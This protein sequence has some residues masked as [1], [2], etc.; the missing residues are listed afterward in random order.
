M[1]SK[2]KF[3]CEYDI[4]WPIDKLHISGLRSI[5]NMVD[6]TVI[7]REEMNVTTTISKFLDFCRVC[8]ASEQGENKDVDLAEYGIE[9]NRETFNDRYF[10]CGK[11][12]IAVGEVYFMY[13]IL[14]RKVNLR[15]FRMFKF[16]DSYFLFL[17]RERYAFIADKSMLAVGF[18][19]YDLFF[20]VHFS[21]Q[22]KIHLG[23]IGY[24]K[25]VPIGNIQ[26]V[27]MHKGA[28]H[29]YVELHYRDMTLNISLREWEILRRVTY[30][31]NDDE[32]QSLV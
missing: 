30:E 11:L 5:F 6:R 8:I 23:Q 26:Y 19:R 10:Y 24:D 20:P 15:R 4:D 2:V 3:R 16:T 9:Y 14:S 27:I 21:V 7:K 31:Y 12:Q 1:G 18:F 22:E 13:E 29:P 17:T 32:Y 28:C 25:R